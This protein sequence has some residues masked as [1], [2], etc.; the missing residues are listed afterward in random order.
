MDQDAC[1]A[2]PSHVTHLGVCYPVSNFS[3]NMNSADQPTEAVT[4]Y[5]GS[6]VQSVPEPGL[7]ALALIAA[8]IMLGRRVCGR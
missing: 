3:I 8:A 7:L 1:L 2:L 4:F 5:A 6:P